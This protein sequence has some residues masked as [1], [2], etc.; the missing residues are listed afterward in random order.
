MTPPV[1]LGGGSLIFFSIRSFG[2]GSNFHYMK[3][4]PVVLVDSFLLFDQKKLRFKL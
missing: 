3:T 2:F 4:T 1:M